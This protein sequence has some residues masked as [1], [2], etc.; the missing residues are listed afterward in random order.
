[1][2]EMDAHDY[3]T[4]QFPNNWMRTGEGEEDQSS[5]RISLQCKRLILIFKDS[6]NDEFGTAHIK[7]DGVFV[8]KVDPRQ[9][10][11]THCHTTLLV[12]EEHVGE[13]SIEIEMAEGHEHKCFTILGFGY[14]D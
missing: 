1:M 6:G 9:V 11:W 12:N 2:A 3:G 14:V 8:Q 7:V 5:F 13:H 10:N 4:P